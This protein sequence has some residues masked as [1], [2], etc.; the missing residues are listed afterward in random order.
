M[1]ILHKRSDPRSLHSKIIDS[2]K[3]LT[4]QTNSMTLW[5]IFHKYR[6]C[7]KNSNSNANELE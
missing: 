5:K 1:H 4:I 6:I 3:Q 7:L 2:M